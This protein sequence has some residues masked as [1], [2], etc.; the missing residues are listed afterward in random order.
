MVS[1]MCTPPTPSNTTT[2]AE[3]TTAREAREATRDPLTEWITWANMPYDPT[4][5]TNTNP[6]YPNN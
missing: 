4:I 2:N 1:D 5:N 6:T 3:W